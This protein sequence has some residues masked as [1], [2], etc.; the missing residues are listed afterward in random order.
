MPGDVWVGRCFVF[1]QG[2]NSPV[3][4]FLSLQLWKHLRWE[5][6]A[7]H[8]IS[9]HIWSAWSSLSFMSR[10]AT[11]S[12]FVFLAWW[13]NVTFVHSI[14]ADKLSWHQNREG[15][16]HEQ[17][18]A[19]GCRQDGG[20]VTLFILHKVTVA[21][22]VPGE[23]VCVNHFECFSRCLNERLSSWADFVNMTASQLST[24]QS[25]NFV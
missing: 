5:T 15:S 10:H 4:K 21:K 2:Q 3:A 25:R 12:D 20:S 14:I 11:C 18:P 23:T 24:T 19:S 1:S 7:G 17:P 9:T 13:W 16:K 8:K 22:C 6:G